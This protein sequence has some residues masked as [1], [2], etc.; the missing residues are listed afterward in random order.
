MTIDARPLAEFW[1]TLP[2][3]SVQF[4]EVRRDQVSG[5]GGGGTLA[6]DLGGM[7]FHGVVTLDTMRWS[8]ARRVHGLLRSLRG[9]A[10]LF[11]ATDPLCAAPAFD[12]GGALL[13]AGPSTV[14]ID[15]IDDETGEVTFAG[16]PADYQ[17]AIGDMFDVVFGS[18]ER[19]ALFSIDADVTA[20]GDGVTDATSV[21]PPLWNGIVAGADV[22]LIRPAGVFF[23]VPGSDRRGASMRGKVSGSTFEIM[24]KL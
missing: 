22:T 9:P 11:Y 6:Y 7:L 5:T 12:P 23:V 4:G 2:I 24:Q 16:L 21:S 15:T 13:S 20:D 10:D 18:P 19:Q 14:T 3:Q 17:L 8:E 1:D